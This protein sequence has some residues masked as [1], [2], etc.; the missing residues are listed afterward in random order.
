MGAKEASTRSE[1]SKKVPYQKC[2]SKDNKLNKTKPNASVLIFG[3]DARTAISD[4][5]QS[6]G[7]NISESF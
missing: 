5:I 4:Q 3:A 1:D 6:E 7:K 2:K